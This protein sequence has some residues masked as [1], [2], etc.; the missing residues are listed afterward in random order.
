MK[1][2]GYFALSEPLGELMIMAW[3]KWQHPIDIV[4]PIPLHLRRQ[5][6]RGYN[7][8]ELLVREMQKEFGWKGDPTMLVRSRQ[9]KPQ[10]GLT[11]IERRAN[12]RG[13][14]GAESSRVSGKRILLVDDVCT[15]GSTLTAPADALLDA[16]AQSVSAYCLTIALGDQVITSA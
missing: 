6:Q 15:T 11:A 14:F 3:P 4:L 16:G 9:T 2:Q 1:Y 7:Q 10:L 13:A 5:R 8:S 12:V